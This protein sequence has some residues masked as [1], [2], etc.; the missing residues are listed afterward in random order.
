M[1]EDFVCVAK[2]EKTVLAS[3]STNSIKATEKIFTNQRTYE[4]LSDQE[5]EQIKINHAEQLSIFDFMKE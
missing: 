4:K 1:P 5:K 3:A 2:T